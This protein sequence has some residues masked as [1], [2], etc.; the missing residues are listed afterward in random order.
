MLTLLDD[1]LATTPTKKSSFVWGFVADNIANCAAI[2]T[3]LDLAAEL[4]ELK[5]L[6]TEDSLFTNDASKFVEVE[7]GPLSLREESYIVVKT[8][9]NPKVIRAGKVVGGRLQQT[10]RNYF[11]LWNEH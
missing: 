7:T 11:V 8:K 6:K 9:K 1:R 2:V 5:F 3:L 4:S 10:L